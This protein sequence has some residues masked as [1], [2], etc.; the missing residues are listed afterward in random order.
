MSQQDIEAA[1]ATACLLS[2]PAS[3]NPEPSLID[4][5]I[6]EVCMAVEWP[7]G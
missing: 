3:G 1:L 5:S 6:F 7:F 2:A 4:L